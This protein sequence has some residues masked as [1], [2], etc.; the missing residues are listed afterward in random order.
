[1]TQSMTRRTDSDTSLLET[2]GN[3]LSSN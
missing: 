1:M 2:V 3:T